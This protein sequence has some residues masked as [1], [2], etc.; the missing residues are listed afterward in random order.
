MLDF[1]AHLYLLAALVVLNWPV[2]QAYAIML[3]KNKDGLYDAIYYWRLPDIISLF[4]GDWWE[5]QWAEFKLFL[6]AAMCVIAVA[7]EY[8]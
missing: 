1:V 4:R 7:A 8:T 5:D 2:Y 3:F 6:F